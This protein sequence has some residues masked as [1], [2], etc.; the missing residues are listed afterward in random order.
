MFFNKNKR[1]VKKLKKKVRKIN[2]FENEIE[3][4][5][6]EELKNKTTE[7]MDRYQNGE[8]L[9]KLLP[10]AFAVVREASKRVLNMR[11]Y[12]VQMMGGIA[13]HNGNIAEMRTGEGKTL[14][15]T[16]PVYLNALTGKAVHVIT[17]NDYLAKRDATEM[18]QI[19][20]FLGLTVGVNH[21]ELTREEKQEVYACNVVY[22]TNNE[23][24]FDYLRDNMVGDPTMKVQG[25]LYYAIIDEV[26]SVLI[27]EA[28]TPLIISGKADQPNELYK[29]ADRLVKKMKEVAHYSIDLKGKTVQLERDGVRLVEETFKIGNLY[30]LENMELNN[31][32][33]LALRANY[34]MHKD[35]DYVV[36]DNKV[37]I[38]DQF[39]GRMMPGRRYSDGLHQAIEAKENVKVENES[40]T[41]ATIT[42]QN[43]FR[44]YEKLSGMTGT[45]KTEENEFKEIYKMKVITIPTN[46][47][48]QRKDETE[49]VYL[50]QEKKYE[51]IAARVA[52]IH[53]TRQPIL[54]GTANIEVSEL[55][56]DKLKKLKVPHNVLNAKNHEREAEIIGDAGKAGS[57]TIA[58]NMA[59]RGTD[60]KLED[61]SKECG[62]LFVIGTERHESRRIDNQLR[63]RSGRQGDPGKSVFYVSLED[64][65]MKRFGK[66]NL[67]EM[68]KKLGYTEEDNIEHKMFSRAL[69]VAQKR[70]EGNNFESRKWLLK[71]DDV[72][73]DQREIVYE[74]RDRI[75]NG[76]GNNDMFLEFLKESVHE[77]I[78]SLLK[79]YNI[80][81]QLQEVLDFLNQ[82]YFMTETLSTENVDLHSPKKFEE[83]VYE[84]IKTIYEQKH[85]E[86]GEEYASIQKGT[87]LR[88]IDKKWINHID[89]MTQLKQGIHLRGYAQNDPLREYQ[90]E[91]YELFDDMMYMVRN[92]I[93]LHMLRTEKAGEHEFAVIKKEEKINAEEVIE[94][95]E[96]TSKKDVKVM[97][98]KMK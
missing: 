17:V 50:T 12:D 43:Y 44:L 63:G 20:Q 67:K 4:L 16:L 9:D 27:D 76:E 52:E 97:F 54:V 85:A 2:A 38:I 96:E 39:T 70:V 59:G 35:N 78:T 62:G 21:T 41:M 45:A 74:I 5:T 33:N 15:S 26:D 89:K 64:E 77:D 55:I 1:E 24:G 51:A 3:K 34:I 84:T 79:T 37:I 87:M 90:L 14:V 47:P 29:K 68:A 93:I 66:M 61:E 75:V 36:Q 56:S 6:D 73:R 8:T 92:E 81:E 53:A 31:H 25:E 72:L 13:L 71:F 49:K 7:F 91:G 80:D 48:V 19:H 95:K 32:I 42:F 98:G 57:V 11:H 88:I 46:R 30:D 83:S 28:R 69:E 40:I 60:I 86:F 58:T 22:G 82:K 94:E 18:G 10:E 23:F 65:L